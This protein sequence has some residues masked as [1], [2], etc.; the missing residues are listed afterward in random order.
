MKELSERDLFLCQSDIRGNAGMFYTLSNSIR[1]LPLS[2]WPKNLAVNYSDHS[3]IVIVIVC[4]VSQT[5]S[6][7][8]VE[9]TKTILG[10]M[11]GF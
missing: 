3:V 4:L 7:V 6:L 1:F 9:F 5:F 8:L 11:K 10:V 2:P